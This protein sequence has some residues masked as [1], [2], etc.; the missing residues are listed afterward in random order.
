MRAIKNM[1][2]VTL[3]PQYKYAIYFK[4]FNDVTA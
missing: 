2:E 3:L 1:T 4:E